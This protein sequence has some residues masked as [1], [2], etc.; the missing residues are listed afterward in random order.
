MGAEKRLF[1]CITVLF[2]GLCSAFAL[3]EIQPVLTNATLSGNQFQF[4]L[5]GESNVAYILTSSSNLHNWTW[6]ITN[7]ESQATR[8]IIVPATNSQTF[9]KVRPVP[10]P[11]FEHAILARGNVNLGGSGRIDSFNSTNLAESTGGQYDPL[12]ATDRATVATPSRTTTALSVGNMS[13]YGSV[14]TGLGAMVT[15]GPN[16]SVG[17]TTF[18]LNPANGGRIEPGYHRDDFRALLP[19]PYLP[20]NFGPFFFLQGMLY[21]PGPGG[22]NYK[23]AIISDGD[24]RGTSISLRD[25]EKM[26][27]NARARL[28]LLSSTTVSGTGYI[29]LGPN[30]SVEWYSSGSVNIS[31]GGCINNSG[32]ATNF[33]IIGFTSSPISYSG[34]A[35][36]IGTIYAPFAAV[37]LSGTNNAIGAIVSTNFTLTGS[38][39]LHFDESL[40]SAGPFF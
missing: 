37:T 31:G 20:M 6:A 8:T 25:G 9:W 40:K 21:P 19:A 18:N 11:V 3:P 2:G 35:P 15:V 7:T 16:G 29:L 26:L 4:T 22:T 38:M 34:G 23:Y 30:A 36:F 28:H 33:L 39:G 13:V 10:G 12:K 5:H 24:Y 17:S 14:M 27:I 1:A 32:R